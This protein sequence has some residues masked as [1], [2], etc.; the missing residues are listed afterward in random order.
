MTTGKGFQEG[1][2]APVSPPHHR[3]VHLLPLF[4]TASTYRAIVEVHRDGRPIEGLQLPFE[5]E[6]VSIANMIRCSG[7][8]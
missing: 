2:L 7:K 3:T 4:I 8:M 5:A 6:K 1:S